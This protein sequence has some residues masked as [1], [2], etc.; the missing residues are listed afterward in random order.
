M[1]F[2]RWAIVLVLL[3]STRLAES[4]EAGAT[5]GGVFFPY[6]VDGA[7]LTQDAPRA[8]HECSCWRVVGA[9]AGGTAGFWGYAPLALTESRVGVSD[10]QRLAEW[11]AVTAGS[12]I[13]G[14]WIGKQFDRR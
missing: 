7:V 14:Y 12:A 3:S 4:G 9:F 8:K 6:E 1:S 5:V 10:G 11:S 13:L 2:Q